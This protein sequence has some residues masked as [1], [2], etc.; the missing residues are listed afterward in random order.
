MNM[1]WEMYSRLRRLNLKRVV[2][3]NDIK[4]YAE[5]KRFLNIKGVMP[6]EETEFLELIKE[7]IITTPT[8]KPSPIED[9]VKQVPRQ[10]PPSPKKKRRRTPNKAKKV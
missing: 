7:S 5:L 10:D 9:N 1:S 8:S 3:K 6:P 4:D 2:E